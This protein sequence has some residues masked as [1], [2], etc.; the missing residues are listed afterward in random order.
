MT[1]NQQNRAGDFRRASLLTLYRRQD[2]QPGQVAI[3]QEVN[4]ANRAHEL[5]SAVL[6]LHQTFITRFRTAEGIDLL[7]DYM[8]GIANLEPVD[9]TS[10]DTVRAAKIID[11]HGHNDFQGIARVMDEAIKDRRPTETILALLDH[12]EVAMPELSGPGGIAFIEAN[13]AA[14][15]E[16]EFRPDDDE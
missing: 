12:Y 3:L 5:L 6:V 7:A 14:M 1:D 13:A 10:T 2:N 16:E 9:P 11:H 4:E 15:R 8:Q